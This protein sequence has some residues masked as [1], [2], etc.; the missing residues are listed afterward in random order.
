[1]TERSTCRQQAVCQNGADGSRV[2]TFCFSILLL[3]RLDINNLAK[4]KSSSFIY[5]FIFGK[6][7]G[8]SNY[9]P[10]S[11][12]RTAVRHILTTSFIMTDTNQA[13]NY[14]SDNTSEFD[15]TNYQVST[16]RDW[17]LIGKWILAI[18]IFLGAPIYLSV[19]PNDYTPFVQVMFSIFLFIMAFILGNKSELSKA[20]RLANDRWLPQ[21]ES[22]IFRLMTLQNNVKRFSNTTS[23][24]SEK[25][26]EQLPELKDESYKAIRIKMR[27]DCEATAQRLIDISNQL[28]DAIEDWRRFIVAN[29]NGD[30]CERIFD[31]LQQRERRLQSGG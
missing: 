31:A 8:H 1:M 4:Y 26:E 10:T 29:C 15:N 24:S 5:K 7:G 19:K 3:F 16:K 25:T 22:V 6:P 23:C 20:A 17:A 14:T 30:E 28:E 27:T 9:S 18:A 11:A 2:S 13:D 21:A 12:S